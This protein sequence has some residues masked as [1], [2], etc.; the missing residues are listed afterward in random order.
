MK[1]TI[2][3]IVVIAILVTIVVVI[4]NNSKPWMLS[5]Y[6]DGLTIMRIDYSS[7]DTCLS[8]GRSYLADNSAE[9]FD[10]GQKCSSFDKNNLQSSPVCKMICNDSGC[11]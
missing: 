1:K 11:R 10:C 7:K 4:N 9:R 5:L 3:I 2:F 8:A 6:R